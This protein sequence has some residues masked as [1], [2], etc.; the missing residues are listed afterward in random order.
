M[1]SRCERTLCKLGNEVLSD[2]LELLGVYCEKLLKPL[3]FCCQILWHIRHGPYGLG[4]A[5][6]KIAK[7]RKTLVMYAIDQ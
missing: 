3:D 1:G 5:F 2:S 6:L 4:L 7:L